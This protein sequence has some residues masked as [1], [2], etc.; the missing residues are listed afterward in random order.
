M[1]KVRNLEIIQIPVLYVDTLCVVDKLN[2]KQKYVANKISSHGLV[3]N[4][5]VTIV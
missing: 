4:T 3:S 5:V 2:C 1:I